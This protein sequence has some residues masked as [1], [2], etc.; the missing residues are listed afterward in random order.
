MQNFKHILFII[1][2]F[3]LFLSFQYN[4]FNIIP[5]NQFQF[6]QKDSESL[7]VGRMVKSKEEGMLSYGALLGWCHPAKELCDTSKWENEVPPFIRF[8]G[9]GY[10]VKYHSNKFF[11]QFEAQEDGLS[12]SAYELYY[13]HPSA[14]AF[15]YSIIERLFRIDGY[16]SA[17]WMR[18]LN[19]FFSALIFSLLVIWTL[20]TFGLVSSIVLFLCLLFSY[21]ITQFGNNI[22]H[23]LGMLYLPFVCSLFFLKSHTGLSRKTIIKHSLLIGSVMLAK[24]LFTGF[25]Y[26]TVAMTMAVVPMF[27]YFLLYRYSYKEIVRLFFSSV[28]SMAIAVVI[29]LTILV[30]QISAVKGGVV[31]GIEYII[32]TFSRRTIG[33]GSGYDMGAIGQSLSVFKVIAR[34]WQVPI[35]DL[36]NYIPLKI[37]FNFCFSLLATCSLFTTFFLKKMR[38]ELRNKQQAL[39]LTLWFS[40]LA[41][42][43][44]LVV[45]KNHCWIHLHMN[46]IIWWMPFLLFGAMFF[47]VTIA[48]LNIRKW[49]KLMIKR[50]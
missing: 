20:E 23:M 22:Y 34:Y 36:S 26:I 11:Y 43:S 15:T 3:L 18:C 17:F 42:L 48:K 8:G 4:Y 40:F 45:F 14:H 39:I 35:F 27:F 19:S 38:V 50:L 9:W 16:D 21:W 46:P 44:W 49:L 12:S 41:P 5:E 47:G 25:E 32:W 6:F 24:C 33:T 28:F 2:F 29:V 1:S 30:L 7:I 37:N 13:S 31:E 10:D